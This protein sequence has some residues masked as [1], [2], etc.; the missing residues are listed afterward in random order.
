MVSETD[1]LK[2]TFVSHKAG[3][4]DHACP[5]KRISNCMVD[6]QV[7]GA[8]TQTKLFKINNVYNG[9]LCHTNSFHATVSQVIDSDVEIHPVCIS[10]C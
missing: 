10:L 8:L 3:L 5:N 9:I 6:H 7:H 2:V 4:T 1:H